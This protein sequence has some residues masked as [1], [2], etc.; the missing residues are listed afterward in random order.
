M[1]VKNEERFL[2]QCL[3]SAKDVV[4]EIVVVDTGSTDR[5]IEI[6]KS[7]GALV[8]ER[9]WRDDFA[10][11]RNQALEAATKRWIL[12]LDADEELMPESRPALATLKNVPAEHTA[13]W[14]RIY[15]K[16]D[17]YR[18]TG[19]MSHAL[20]RVFPNV[21]EIRYCGLIHEFPT[22]DG[23]RNGLRGVTSPVGIVH[24]GYVKE[25]V[26]QREKGARNLAIVRAAAQQEP[27]D[28]FHWFNL[29]TTAFLVED[30]AT[31]RDGLERMREM[32]GKEKRG[33]MPN[34]LAVL[35]ETYCDKLGDPR[36]G[37][38]VAR[39]ALEISPHYAN[40]HF[41]L[42]KALVAQ[43]RFEEARAAY[44]AA[45]ED[46]KY[47]TQQYVIDDQVYIWKAH[48]EIGSTYV[49]QKDDERALEWFEKGLKNA[50]N[51]EPLHVN[52]A[53]ALERLERLEEAGEAYRDVYEMHRSDDSA[54]EYVNYLLRRHRDREALAI[55]DESYPNFAPG[56][57]VPL[58]M[59]AAA[60]CQ[61][62]KSVD[63]ERYLR[64][65]AALTPGSAEVLNPLEALLRERS[66]AGEVAA[67]VE[68][69]DAV[70]PSA[71]GDFARR[72]RRAIES[73]R[74]VDA[75]ELAKAGLALA[76]GDA[77]LQYAL[78]IALS[79]IGDT[80]G[81]I[82]SL[83]H[84]GEAGPE[85]TVS[86]LTLRASLLQGRGR[87]Q[88]G[89]ACIDRALAIGPDNVDA[90]LTHAALMQASG[91]DAGYEGSLKRAFE[92]DKMR[93]ALELSSFYLRNNRFGEAAA[94]ADS[95]LGK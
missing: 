26:F 35:A 45:I 69:E 55:V 76:P 24:H 44:L 2:A 57:A 48:S 63:D 39:D 20:I 23:D 86:I 77:L 27:D 16:S 43:Q 1:I 64:A 10:W 60:V 53:R 52:R 73:E 4:D 78:A 40:A 18:G 14:A 56:K 92:L 19:A 22:V 67:L 47:A 13:L 34:G 50:P 6:A 83:E 7:Y 21:P 11:A 90:L 80:A 93:V 75:R 58:L 5:T 38:E 51:A 8:L 84:I 15:N 28:P 65:A 59:A 70:P 46:G 42:G 54:I 31:A 74:F 12:I 9:P 3:E 85:L 33:F 94:I 41:Q 49:M 68:A 61:R 95:A 81:A 88:E 32:L 62:E 89:L 72:A 82:D 36:K 25:I 37:E 71:P 66:K 29:G 30:Y 91:S 79:K 17:D 87:L